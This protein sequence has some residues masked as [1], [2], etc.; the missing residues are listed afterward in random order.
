MCGGPTTAKPGMADVAWMDAALDEA[1][2]AYDE[3]EVPIG[4]VVVVDGRMVGRG[5]NEVD[6]QGDPTAHAEILAIGAAC[7]SL[8][9][10]RLTEGTIYVTMEPCPMCAGAIVLARLRR[11]V[12]GCPDPKAGYCG[13]LGNIPDDPKLNH[14]VAVT[15]GVKGDECA[16]LVSSF[17]A[18]I[19]A[20]GRET[21]DGAP[22]TSVG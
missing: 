4:A 7:R 8:G 3:G 5:H 18:H 6:R 1:R 10:P 15:S 11:L 21:G 12:Y 19:R 17:F 9:V 13:T 14:R 16:A 2:R 20:K 22:E